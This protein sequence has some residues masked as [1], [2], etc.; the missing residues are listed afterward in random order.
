MVDRHRIALVW[1]DGS[2]EAIR[3][4]EDETILVAAEAAGVSLPFG[5]RTGACASCTARLVDGAVDSVRPPRGLRA[6]R[7][8]DGYVL[9]CVAHPRTDCRIA[10]GADVLADLASRPWE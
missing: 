2:E 6:R 5:C 3:A 10:V 4:S 7:R 9:C 1:R 8:A